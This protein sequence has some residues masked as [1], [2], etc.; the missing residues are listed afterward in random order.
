MLSMVSGE[1]TRFMGDPVSRVA[2]G[3]GCAGPV[4]SC[5]QATFTVATIVCEWRGLTPGGLPSSAPAPRL[6]SLSSAITFQ[7]ATL[8]LDSSHRAERSN[9][10][11]C[12]NS[13]LERLAMNDPKWSSG[14]PAQAPIAAAFYGS[15]P[16]LELRPLSTGELLDRVFFLYRARM[17][18]FLALALAPASIGLLVG[19]AQQLF[20]PAK[21]RLGAGRGGASQTTG[22]GLLILL[23]TRSSW[24]AMPLCRRPLR[25]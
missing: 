5:K 25:A 9:S 24:W 19:V 1:E 6:A 20:L 4:E 21:M 10:I 23:C 17:T 8:V 12:D 22:Q 11:A 15:L 2:L 3:S 18:K 16:S 13:F 7:P 14:S